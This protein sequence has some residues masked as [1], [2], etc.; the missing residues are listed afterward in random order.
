MNKTKTPSTKELKGWMTKKEMAT[1]YDVTQL[2]LRQWIIDD[3]QLYNLLRN[4][5]YYNTQKGFNAK[6][7]TILLK[8]LGDPRDN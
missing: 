1:F 7:I 8:V 3:K 4:A 2:R 6:Q 5:G